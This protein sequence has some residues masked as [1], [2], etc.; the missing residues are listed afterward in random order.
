[1]IAGDRGT[2]PLAHE[3]GEEQIPGS[4]RRGDVGLG[5]GERGL[6]E[7]VLVDHMPAGTH[8]TTD[9]T[10]RLLGGL[11]VKQH[12]AAICEVERAV[13]LRPIERVDVGFYQFDPLQTDRIEH[14]ASDA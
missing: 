3:D 1:V 6:V 5:A 13:P 7:D 12:E 8:E 2:E 4:M 14:A 10:E 11:L 9:A